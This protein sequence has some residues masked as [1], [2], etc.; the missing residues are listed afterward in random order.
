MR[1]EFDTQRN[2]EESPKNNSKTEINELTKAVLIGMGVPFIV[3]AANFIV[4]IDFKPIVWFFIVLWFMIGIIA[5]VYYSFSAAVS[6]TKLASDCNKRKKN[7]KSHKAEIDLANEFGK[8][9]LI[10]QSDIV[11]QYFAIKEVLSQEPGGAYAILTFETAVSDELGWMVE[12]PTFANANKYFPNLVGEKSNYAENKT[13]YKEVPHQKPELKHMRELL[14]E[15]FSM[16]EK[17]Y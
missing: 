1:F 12:V 11:P 4:K 14:L 5:T 13:K 9:Y 16:M 6:S 7:R 8:K 17:I 3:T 15:Q 2:K 10:S